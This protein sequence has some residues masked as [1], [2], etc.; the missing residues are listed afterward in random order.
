M[1]MDILY[2]LR[3]EEVYIIQIINVLICNYQFGLSHLLDCRVCEILVEGDIM[4]VKNVSMEVLWQEST[5]QI[6][7]ENIIIHSTAAV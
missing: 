5:L 2:I 3:M 4:P 6:V 1:R 7:E